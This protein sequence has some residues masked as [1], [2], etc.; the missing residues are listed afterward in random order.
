MIAEDAVCNEWLSWAKE[1]LI[2][3]IMEP[4]EFSSSR[5]LKVLDSPNEGATYC[6][7]F[8]S[9]TAA[10]IDRYLSYAHD[11]V[12]TELRRLFGERVVMFMTV[13]EY[14]D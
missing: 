8:F 9:D 12:Q 7:Q 13:M 4:K 11:T 3:G 1:S 14:I 2:P 10:Q 5:L 6:I